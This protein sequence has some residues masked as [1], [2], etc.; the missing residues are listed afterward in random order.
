[1]L[2]KGLATALFFCPTLLM[3]GIIDSYITVQPI[4]VCDSGGANCA[5]AN[6][7]EA[8]TDKIFAQAGLDVVFLP[9]AQVN[10]STVLN[11]TS[12]AAFGNSGFGR[13]SN[14][15]TINMWFVNNMPAASGTLFGEAW[16]DGNGVAIN[17][18][19]VNSF[20]N[21]TGR[22][23]TVAHELGHN[24]GLGHAIF[25]AIRPE[26]LMTQGSDRTVP[27]SIS[28]I[29]PDGA[30]LS[31]LSILQVLDIAN[32]AFVREIPEVT[33]DMIGST[34]FESSDFFKIAF[35]GGSTEAAIASL[36]IDLSP[37]NAFFDVTNS[38]PGVGG[39]PFRFGS[40]QGVQA[41]EISV[42]WLFD[43]SQRLTLNFSSGAFS[44]GDSLSFGLD[45]DLF[46]NIDG[47]GATP[48]E[49][50]GSIIS[51]E[52][53]DGYTSTSNV[54]SDL[55]ASST[56]PTGNGMVSGDPS[57]GGTPPPNVQ[58]ADPDPVN[59]VPEPSTLALLLSGLAWQCRKLRRRS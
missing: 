52:F 48:D 6:T 37:A 51:F 34:P 53:E 54:A 46:S 35:M 15:T 8:V 40:L 43:G 13:H 38:P 58:L 26:N 10:D 55:I 56:R 21:N 19:A 11:P 9:T 28:D 57:Y 7:F 27:S 36:T 3:A 22:I 30:G 4:Q 41:S 45:V 2:K 14:S 59:P 18:T 33:F 39:S 25:G 32:S 23:D 1:M 47:F 12:V 16:L 31:N 5:T 49:L 20:N 42:E 29:E 44:V 50:V 24:L 17:S